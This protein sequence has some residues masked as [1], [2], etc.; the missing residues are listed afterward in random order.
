M[1]A[2][3]A[4]VFIWTAQVGRSAVKYGQRAYRY[5]YLDAGHIGQNLHLAAEALGLGCCM[6]AA[7]L[8]DEANRILGV[9]GE[10]ETVLYMGAVGRYQ[11][12]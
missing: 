10:E 3:A 6:A 7:L 12:L 2:S 9:D 8:D 5:I 4:C 1:L 11:G